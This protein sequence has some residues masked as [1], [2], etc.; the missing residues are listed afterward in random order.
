MFTS[1][2]GCAVMKAGTHPGR[3]QAGRHRVMSEVRGLVKLLGKLLRYFVLCVKTQRAHNSAAIPVTRGRNM[4]FHSLYISLY[5]D[6]EI[7]AA[8]K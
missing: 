5:R 6:E 8:G 3:S 7:P 2:Y 1:G 4:L